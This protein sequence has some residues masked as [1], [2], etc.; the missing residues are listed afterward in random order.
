MRN[1]IASCESNQVNLS[2]AKQSKVKIL[3]Y[4]QKKEKLFCLTISKMNKYNK[5]QI[6][7]ILWL[8]IYVK[9]LN[10]T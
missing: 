2:K 9:D 3:Y 5:Q 8:V 6:N 7:Q 4:Y 10:F 1:F